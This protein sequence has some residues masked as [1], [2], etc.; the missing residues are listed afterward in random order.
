MLEA[1]QVSAFYL[2]G[3]PENAVLVH[4]IKG[5][6]NARYAALE[7]TLGKSFRVSTCYRYNI[8]PGS[9]RSLVPYLVFAD[10]IAIGTE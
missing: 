7:F 6:W 4:S 9:C 8:V 3:C 5:S 1:G 10:M 2:A